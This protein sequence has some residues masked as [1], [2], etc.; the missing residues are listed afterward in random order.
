MQSDPVQWT[1]T[2]ACA[3]SLSRLRATAPS[4]RGPR[5][6]ADCLFPAACSEL[7][8]RGRKAPSGGAVCQGLIYL[9]IKKSELDSDWKWVRI[10]LFHCDGVNL[11]RSNVRCDQKGSTKRHKDPR[12][13]SFVA[14]VERYTILGHKAIVE[15][16]HIWYNEYTYE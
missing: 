10:S 4:R 14:P 2:A 7:L 1:S 9:Q 16:E 8:Q 12:V 13:D 5:V 11:C 6:A 3:F 15:E